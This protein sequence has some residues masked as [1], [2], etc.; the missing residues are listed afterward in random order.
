[1]YTIVFA[2]LVKAD[3]DKGLIPENQISMKLW[4]NVLNHYVV[5]NSSR[6]QL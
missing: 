1:M 4:T 2:L 5:Q 6:H 3:L